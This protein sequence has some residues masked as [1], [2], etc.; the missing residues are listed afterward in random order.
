MRGPNY[1]TGADFVALVSLVPPICQGCEQYLYPLFPSLVGQL[2]IVV[3]ALN[4]GALSAIPGRWA[5]FEDHLKASSVRAAVARFETEVGGSCTP[6]R[7]R[8]GSADTA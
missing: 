8:Q 4:Q 5:I 2:H 3:E 6:L 7:H 1:L